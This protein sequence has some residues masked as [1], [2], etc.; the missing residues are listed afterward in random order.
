VRWGRSRSSFGGISRYR[1]VPRGAAG[2]DLLRINPTWRQVTPAHVRDRIHDILK[3]GMGDSKT[4]VVVSARG[5]ITLPSGLR[6]RLGIRDGGVVTV[7]ERDG[8]LILRPAA[9]VELT[10]YGDEEIARWNAEDALDDA[11]RRRIRRK[12]TRR[13]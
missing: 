6:R 4:S 5:Q 10:M 13:T 12:L 11:E 2:D 7:E 9:V 8:A 1:S 3:I